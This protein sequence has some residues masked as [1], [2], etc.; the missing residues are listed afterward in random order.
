MSTYQVSIS[1]NPDASA[2]V[3]EAM[4]LLGGMS[5]FVN[6]GERV[7]I[8][9]N[10]LFQ[11]YR[12]GAVADPAV[13][14][15]VA[16]LVLEA[17]GTPII[18][19]N[20][21]VYNPE[22]PQ[23]ETS[24]GKYYHEALAAIGLAEAV[25]LVD[26]TAGEMREVDFPD[27]KVITRG[28]IT[29]VIFD[30]DKIIDIPILK[31]HD[32]TQVSLGIKN[33][34]GMLPVSE[35]I[36]YHEE[37]LEQAIV[38]LCGFVKPHLVIIDGTTAGEGLGPAEC[39]PVRMDL[40]IAGANP[41]AT[42]MVGAAVMGFDVSR[43][44]FLKYAVAAGLGPKRLDEVEVLGLPIDAV[45]CRF[46]TAEEAATRQYAEMGVDVISRNVCSGC[47]AE[48]RHIYYSLGADR[49]KLAGLTFA[50]GRL[51]ELPER[52]KVVV[53][54]NC[55]KAVAGCGCFVPGCPPHHFEIDAAAREVSGLGGEPKK[56]GT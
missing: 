29:P 13:V 47:W 30:V 51:E 1:K 56:L 43:I 10:G 38:D 23:F 20:D 28:A 17:G 26:L 6:P 41:L 54:G 9:P 2:A 48:F 16:R 46:V 27:G 3:R 53:V 18:G 35:R 40:V 45:A 32:Q 19:E 34:K 55:A 52:E 11:T 36:R 25:P 44:K 33:L 22:S 31:T 12:L 50:L 7:L 37:N 42:D 5:Q 14:A 39:T 49:A 8:K 4:D 15:E 21:L 24:V